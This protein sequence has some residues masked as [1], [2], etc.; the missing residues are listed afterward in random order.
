MNDTTTIICLIAAAAV[1][2]GAS[3]GSSMLELALQDEGRPTITRAID[4][5][6]EASPREVSSGDDVVFS[7]RVGAEA[8]LREGFQ[9]RIFTL[10]SLD[11]SP[12]EAGKPIDDCLIYFSTVYP[13]VSSQ[14]AKIPLISNAAEGWLSLQDGKTVGNGYF[15]LVFE[16][17]GVKE[18]VFRIRRSDAAAYFATGIRLVVKA[19]SKARL[20][21]VIARSASREALRQ[22][23]AGKLAMSDN[24]I[25]CYRYE[26]VTKF[27]GLAD[28]PQLLAMRACERGDPRS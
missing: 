16:R 23:D 7:V 21:E 8:V 12:V 11:A 24:Q 19:N 9:V 25:R 4:V 1:Q 2:T 22:A 15:L 20:D 10:P 18:S 5:V 6:N 3:A 17:T 13:V 27:A 14:G 28:A 26:R